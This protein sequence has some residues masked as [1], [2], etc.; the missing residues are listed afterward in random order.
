MN[1]ITVIS[2]HNSDCIRAERLIDQIFALNRKEQKGCVFLIFAP[3]VPQENR[4]KVRISAEVTFKSTII[5]N[6][7]IPKEIENKASVSGTHAPITANLMAQAADYI[8]KHCHLPWLWLEPDSLPVKS[9]WMENI[10]ETYASQ[11]MR[12]MASHLKVQ[13]GDKEQFFI[14]RMGVY[15]NDAAAD[16]KKATELGAS[17]ES[18]VFGMSS[19]CRLF[20]QISIQSPDDISKLRPDVVLAHS[21]KRAE[22]V[23]VI[24][25][26]ETKSPETIAELVSIT[27]PKW[28]SNP[29]PEQIQEPKRP[30]FQEFHE[31]E[32]AFV[33]THEIKIPAKRGP[34]PKNKPPELATV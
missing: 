27:A 7:D 13:D 11:P 1:L 20:Q 4:D 3:S 14:S 6:A 17:I 18:Y 25:E 2:C 9:G 23:D 30:I 26:K 22:L 29:T 5:L 32:K 12:Y 8:H 28:A 24:V 15:P 33:S 21:D 19:K 31:N 16:F 34:K 10:T